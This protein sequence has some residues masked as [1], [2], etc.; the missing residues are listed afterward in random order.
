MVVLLEGVAPRTVAHR[1]LDEQCEHGF[2]I[3]GQ[4]LA[5][6]GLLHGLYLL[7]GLRH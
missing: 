5:D 2:R 7:I 3:G 1:E 4:G 6:Y